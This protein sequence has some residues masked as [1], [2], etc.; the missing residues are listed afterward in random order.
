MR[1]GAV[2]LMTSGLIRGSSR[3]KG[4]SHDLDA[5]RWDFDASLTRT[6]SCSEALERRGPMIDEP[7][8]APPDEKVASTL[9]A[10]AY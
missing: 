10:R 6:A 7:A 3:G 4:F 2:L 5:V 1:R 9:P 8:V